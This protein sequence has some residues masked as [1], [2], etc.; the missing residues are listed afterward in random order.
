MKLKTTKILI[1]GAI[2]AMSAS[3]LWAT[4]EATKSGTDAATKSELGQPTRAEEKTMGATSGAAVGTRSAM[5]NNRMSN[6]ALYALSADK[7]EGMEVVDRSGEK[8]GTIKNIVLA[9]DRHSAHAVITSGGFLGMGARDIMVSLGDLRQ[10]SEDVLQ[11]SATQEQ[12]VA[13]Q[14]YSSDAYAELKG[15]DP[16]GVSFV[17]FS[18]FEEGKDLP[19]S[20]SQAD[21]SVTRQTLRDQETARGST[22]A[23]ARA[24]TGQSTAT[25]A[26]MR[27]ETRP[28]VTAGSAVGD[29]PLYTRSAANLNGVEVVNGAG[30]SFGKVK[31]VVLVPTRDSAQVVVSTGGVLGMGAR[32]ILLSLDDLTPVGD[33]LQLNATK[34]QI[35]AIQDYTPQQYVEIKGGTPIS[36]SIVDFS[37]LE[38]DKD[39]ARS[40]NPKVAK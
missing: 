34:E 5:S 38:V 16:I 7:L 30:E 12:I 26:Q 11:M 37:A 31:Q 4:G 39:G 20:R 13:L 15:D 18:P 17:R 27:S 19:S 1:A 40:N 10:T 9:P 2:V 32:D 29:N 14:D 21:E 25:M 22:N 36:G 8:V 24:E 33:N 28:A 6:T 35:D 3:P 23:N